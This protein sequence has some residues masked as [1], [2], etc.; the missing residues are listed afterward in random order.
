MMTKIL[1]HYTVSLGHNELNVS[2]CDILASKSIATDWY[3][4]VWAS[5]DYSESGKDGYV[6]GQTQTTEHIFYLHWNVLYIM[7][8]DFKQ[9]LICSQQ[10]ADSRIVYQLES[11]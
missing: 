7:W 4:S 8:N 2:Q 1:E 6:G 11:C 9:I 10:T 5:I 3:F